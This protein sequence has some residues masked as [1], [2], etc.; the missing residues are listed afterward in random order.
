[1]IITEEK[2]PKNGRIGKIA[3]IIEK[4]ISKE[5]MLIILKGSDKYKSLSPRDKT[6]WWKD[7]IKRLEKE[8]GTHKAEEIL[9]IY[10]NTGCSQTYKKTERRK[11]KINF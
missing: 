8:I 2:I 5:F 9:N 4:E 3:K 7:F 6:K 11:F 10:V 1:M